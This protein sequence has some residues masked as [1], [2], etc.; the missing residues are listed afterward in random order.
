[1]G[2][3]TN[4]PSREK[5]TPKQSSDTL[6]PHKPP[7]E[8]DTQTYTQYSGLKEDWSLDVL[9]GQ[10]EGGICVPE[11]VSQNWAQ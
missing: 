5:G 2:S 4:G 1:M 8:T 6:A 7:I 11:S 3:R 9:D 10:L